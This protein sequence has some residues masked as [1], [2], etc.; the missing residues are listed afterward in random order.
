M[1]TILLSHNKAAY[2]KVMRAFETSDRTCVVHP[3]GIMGPEDFA[4]GHTTKVLAQIING[5]MSAAIDGSF[6]LGVASLQDFLCFGAR[7]MNDLPVL[8]TYSLQP[9]VIV[10]NHLVKAFFRRDDVIVAF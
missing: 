3:T 1:R 7:L 5:E 6:N 9:L 8:G 4:V 2:Q 10:G